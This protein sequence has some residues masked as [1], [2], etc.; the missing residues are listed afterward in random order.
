LEGRLIAS[1]EEEYV[2]GPSQTKRVEVESIERGARK[3]WLNPR[4]R[5]NSRME[6]VLPELVEDFTD[7]DVFWCQGNSR[8]WALAIWNRDFAISIIFR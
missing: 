2:G 3:L 4:Q 6:N 7:N 1:D 5:Q 8:I